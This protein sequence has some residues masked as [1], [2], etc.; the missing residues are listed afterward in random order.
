[1]R[2]YWARIRT[3]A[4]II[5]FV[6]IFNMSM[7]TFTSYATET[8]ATVSG[9]NAGDGNTTVSGNNAGDETTTEGGND[10]GGETTTVSGNN[11]AVMLTALWIES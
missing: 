1:M 10:A 2:H 6:L 8:A 5:C 4:M 7:S 9:N 3:V 11:A